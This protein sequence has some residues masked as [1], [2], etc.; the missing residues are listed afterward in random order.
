MFLVLISLSAFFIYLIPINFI[1]LGNVRDIVK[2]RIEYTNKIKLNQIS[3]DID[4]SFTHASQV[5]EYLATNKQLNRYLNRI[6]Y[7]NI[8][9][10]E[11]NEIYNNV[12]SLLLNF[13]GYSPLI[14]NIDIFTRNNSFSMAQEASYSSLR[15]F[16][17]TQFIKEEAYTERDAANNPKSSSIVAIND[18]MYM[19][20]AL[21]DGNTMVGMIFM[22]ISN[23]FFT[24]VTS[25]SERF[26]LVNENSNTV[27]EGQ[28]FSE[29]NKKISKTELLKNSKNDIIYKDKKYII[30]KKNIKY[31]NWC[32]YYLFSLEPFINTVDFTRG[33]SIIISIFAFCTAFLFSEFISAK[34]IKPIIEIISYTHRYDLYDRIPSNL[35]RLRLK[36]RTS[37]REKTFYYLLITIL[38]P[39]C[40]YVILFYYQSENVITSKVTD[41]YGMVFEN[42]VTTLDDD[43]GRKV[44]A[45]K[46]LSFERPIQ[47]LILDKSSAR[48]DV[49]L[50]NTL[51]GNSIVGLGKSITSIVN[52]DNSVLLTNSLTSDGMIDESFFK[53]LTVSRKPLMWYS[54]ID[55]LGRNN[56]NLVTP[57]YN[58]MSL[59][60]NVPVGYIKT[61]IDQA[62]IYEK[63][64]DIKTNFSE[65]M[66][67]DQNGN[68]IIPGKIPD[69]KG[70][71][72]MWTENGVKYEITVVEG[73]KYI[74]YSASLKSIPWNIVCSY[75]MSGQLMQ[76]NKILQNNIIYTVLIAILLIL[77]LSYFIS[78]FIAKPVDNFNNAIENIKIDNL[79]ERVRSS[80]FIDEFSIMG[81]AFNEM[82]D[83]IENLINELILSNQKRLEL[84]TQKKRAEIIA[85]Q[86]QINPHFLYNTLDTIN[87]MVKDGYKDRAVLMINALSDLFRYGL[88]RGEMLISIIEEIEYA[89][90][91]T[92][93]MV[94][95]YNN[96]IRFNWNIEKGLLEYK[97]IK[98]IIQPLIENSIYHGIGAGKN[99]GIVNISC[100]NE[101]NCIK[102]I[103]EDNGA[104][105]P[106]DRLEEIKD[107]LMNSSLK[108]MHGIYNVQ[109]RIHIYYGREYGIEIQSKLGE[110]TTVIMTIP[111][112]KRERDLLG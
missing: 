96:K 50:I 25:E 35:A 31:K 95:R 110:G 60:F 8:G 45:M 92:D 90:A 34:I 66:I 49:L 112:I 14:C 6:E 108:K 106:E 46:K 65:V 44:T 22:Q 40:A 59:N 53:T 10:S 28:K 107:N 23:N 78:K 98:L 100:D 54:S 20:Q 64:S 70:K 42:A 94:L 93:I 68:V 17:D 51:E 36:D 43:I 30:Y 104:G 103:V 2:D 48:D 52:T 97:T 56:I 1:L 29:I 111:K 5:I 58:M 80:Y 79:R 39:V 26:L 61:E 13:S 71:N 12:I 85:L 55:K 86:S 102:F 4:S 9:A 11:K 37:L 63:Y 75:E 101:S 76:S 21:Y 38:I 87:Y 82:I 72:F 15:D 105:M 91:Y 24:N 99:E 69:T 57:V 27:W 3:S 81:K 47:Q 7:I 16:S 73:V 88:S 109:A 62:M 83:R 84:E 18:I 67:N 77:V 33:F 41:T 89:K 19:T 74:V 32:V